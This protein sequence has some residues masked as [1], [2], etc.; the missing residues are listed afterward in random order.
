MGMLVL[1][2]VV[3]DQRKHRRRRIDVIVEVVAEDPA[4]SSTQMAHVLNG[5]Q[6]AWCLAERG[7]STSPSQR[8]VFC[9]R[10][11]WGWSRWRIGELCFE[12][13]EELA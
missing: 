7:E 1:S 2:V 5:S 11:D 6:D 10:V 3:F 13:D 12:A 9:V 8:T 4:V